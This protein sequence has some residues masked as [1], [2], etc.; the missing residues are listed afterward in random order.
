MFNKKKEYINKIKKEYEIVKDEEGRSLIE[1]KVDN[2]DSVLSSFSTKEA[3]ISNELAEFINHQLRPMTLTNGIHL[4]LI[5]DDI[6]D[7]EK[8]IYDS[9]IR[10]YY[11][12]EL[13]EKNRELTRNKVL[14]W[15][16]G[17]LGTIILAVSILL[18][19]LE[20]L[21]VFASV[22]DIV[23][24]VLLW[25]AV[26]LHIFQRP[27]IEIEELKAYEIANSIITYNDNKVE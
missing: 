18:S 24:W 8:K 11:K 16:M 22:I 2:K 6:T 20:K 7:E 26:D 25:E 21:T 12:H 13:I 23:A 3:I 5:C 27:K 1:I 10:N 15:V 19:V 14:V 4:N 9:A 17:I